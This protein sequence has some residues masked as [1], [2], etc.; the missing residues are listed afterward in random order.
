MLALIFACVMALTARPALAEDFAIRSAKVYVSP[1]AR[2]I[3]DCTIIIRNGKIAALGRHLKTPRGMRVLDARG[4]VAVAGFWNSH[5]HILTHDLLHADSKPPAEL[6]RTLGAML[7]RWGFTTVFDLAS[8]L[9]NTTT[10]R[11]LIERGVVDGPNI[12]T[13]G[14]PFYPPNGTPGYIRQFLKDEH[15]AAPISV[16]VPQVLARE[17]Y[18]LAHGADGVK[19]FTGSIVGGD[20]GVLPMPLKMARALTQG[21][22]R[23]GKPVFAHPSNAAGVR[24]AIDS[25]VN[26]LAHTAPMMGQWNDRVVH[27]LLAHH[28]ALIP[29]LTLFAVEAKK[30]GESPADTAHDIATAVQQLSIFA[31]S[32]GDVLFGTDVGYTD[33][34]DTTEEYRLMHRA[35]LD[36]REILASLTTTPARRFGMAAHKGRIAKGMDAD[37]VVLSDDP[38][39]DVTAFARVAWTIRGGRII[40]DPGIH[41]TPDRP[42]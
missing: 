33:A 31:R 40:F 27:R 32:G 14:E 39:N 36:W 10:V 29:T 1:T 16:G 11:K 42:R 23:A 28:M 19:L 4:K 15:I 34:F 8:M 9:S 22:H 41:S 20:V 37:L 5:V 26:I 7:N 35:G 13:V 3:D 18:E 2:P 12:L 30:F 17:R 6:S 38:A 24:I 25:G 21:S